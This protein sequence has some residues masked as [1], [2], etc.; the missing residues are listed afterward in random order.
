MGTSWLENYFYHVYFE[1]NRM[2]YANFSGSQMKEIAFQNCNLQ[3]AN[4]EEV[5]A[6]HLSLQN[7]NLMASSFFHTSLKDIDLTT[8]DIEG[9]TVG[10]EE[11]KG[12]IV[13]PMQ[14]LD[15]SKLLG[16]VIKD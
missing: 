11:I 2:N 3:E 15:L 7:C 8:C 1:E 10:L 4:V 13:N 5:K 14:A 6:K 9:I 16:I 12:T